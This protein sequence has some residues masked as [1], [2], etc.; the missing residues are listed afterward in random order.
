MGM[1]VVAD[2]LARLTQVLRRKPEV[3]LSADA[4]AQAQWSGPQAPLRVVC[5]HPDG[6]EVC[7]D[8]PEALGGGGAA[9]SPGW[10]Y[11]AGLASCATS[12]IAML[13]ASEGVALTT[14]RVEAT[15]QSDA[16]GLLALEDADG[17]VVSAAPLDQHLLIAIGAPDTTPEQL[18]A[19]VQRALLRSPIP[20]AVRAQ[21]LTV[22]VDAA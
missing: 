12:S 20:T 9:V 2:A 21:G 14:L 6:R 16:R 18:R 11:R 7:T 3:G 22:Q 15:S 4:P 10:L 17:H 13:A 1:Q 5:R 19:L 8:L